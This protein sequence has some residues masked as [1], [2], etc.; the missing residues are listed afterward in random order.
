MSND[1][2]K[3]PYVPDLTEYRQ[4]DFDDDEICSSENWLKLA[5]EELYNWW[6][7][8]EH[9]DDRSLDYQDNYENYE[10]DCREYISA[11]VNTLV[12]CYPTQSPKQAQIY[13]A[14]LV[15][16]LL[17]FTPDIVQE[18]MRVIRRTEKKFPTVAHIYQAAEKI[19]DLRCQHNDLIRSELNRIR[20]DRER[21]EKEAIEAEQ[22]EKE[23][24][25]RQ[26]AQARIDALEEKEEREYEF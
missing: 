23:R 6:G 11:S 26:Y 12:G 9:H 25:D 2:T 17:D 15:D 14:V 22:K 3:P 18:A 8:Q 24:L 10:S 19:R 4:L 20:W 7:A 13:K 1:V 5:Q 21:K 16:E